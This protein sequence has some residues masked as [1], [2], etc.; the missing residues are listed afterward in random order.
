MEMYVAG[1]WQGSAQTTPVVHPY[2]GA[3]IDEVPA[4]EPRQVDAALAAAVDGAAAMRRLTAHDRVAML[5]RAADLLDAAVD[6]LART[7]SLESG[8][9]LKEA[10]AEAARAGDIVRLSAF[11]GARM[12]GETIPVDASAG[13]ADK[14]GFTIRQPCGVVVAI[15]PFNFPLLL[16]LHK[17]APALAAGN[18]VI[19]KPAEQTPLTAL[20]L[21]RIL[22]EAGLPPNSIQCVCGPGPVVGPQLCSDPRVRKISFTG[23]TAV[24]EQITRVAGVKRLS[25]ELGSNAPLVVLSDGDIEAAASAAARAGYVNAGQVCISVQRILVDRAHYGD[26]LDA[27]T[28]RVQQL[29]VGDPFEEATA[30]S[31]LISETAAKRVATLVG[32]AVE[33]GASLVTGGQRTGSVISPGVL[34]DARPDMGVFASELFGPMVAVA[35]VDGVDEAIAIAND[36]RYGLAAGVF[37]ASI[38]TAMRFAAEVDVGTV[39]INAPPLWRADPMPYGGLKGSGIGKEGPRYAIDEMTEL[40]AVILHGLDGATAAPTTGVRP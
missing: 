38:S 37:T 39:Q 32:D 10:R 21:T 23:S 3:I 34:A 14:F 17:L 28:P 31:A 29:Q 2:S 40:K 13:N 5:D 22:L 35:A 6:D 8:K 20:K 33:A 18:A 7:I 12:H 25:L 11:E 9:P 4:A 19:A 27:L 30:V 36:T 24:G 15:S 26:Y 16:L 1:R